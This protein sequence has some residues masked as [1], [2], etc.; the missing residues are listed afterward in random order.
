MEQT[1]A[2][3]AIQGVM[4]MP[5]YTAS[6]LQRVL[7]QGIRA[8]LPYSDLCDTELAIKQLEAR[9]VIQGAL[10]SDPLLVSNLQSALSQGRDANL[11][12]EELKIVEEILGA[13]ETLANLIA[14]T[15]MR[16]RSEEIKN[17]TAYCMPILRG[18]LMTVGMVLDILSRDKPFE[19]VLVSHHISH[20]ISTLHPCSRDLNAS[21][22]TVLSERLPSLVRRAMLQIMEGSDEMQK[23]VMHGMLVDVFRMWKD[24]FAMRAADASACQWPRL[25]HCLIGLPW[26]GL[27]WQAC[28][29]GPCAHLMQLGTFQTM[30]GAA[31]LVVV[32]PCVVELE[33]TFHMDV[34]IDWNRFIRASPPDMESPSSSLVD[35]LNSLYQAQLN[36]GNA[37]PVMHMEWSSTM[38]STAQ[39]RKIRLEVLLECDLDDCQKLE[40]AWKHSGETDVHHFFGRNLEVSWLSSRDA[41]NSSTGYSV[42]SNGDRFCLQLPAAFIDGFADQYLLP[43][44]LLF[45]FLASFGPI[46]KPVKVHR[47]HDKVCLETLY[48]QCDSAQ[49]AHKELAGRYLRL[50]SRDFNPGEQIAAVECAVDTTCADAPQIAARWHPSPESQGA[51]HESPPLTLMPRL[52]SCPSF[53]VTGADKAKA[54]DDAW[55]HSNESEDDVDAPEG[56]TQ[57]EDD[58]AMLSAD[59]D[60]P[61]GETQRENG[62]AM[63]AVVSHDERSIDDEDKDADEAGDKTLQTMRSMFPQRSCGKKCGITACKKLAPF[64]TEAALI[65]HMHDRH[66]KKYL[67]FLWGPEGVRRDTEPYK[68]TM[69]SI[70][71]MINSRKCN[72]RRCKKHHIE[73]NASKL[74]KHLKDDHFQSKN[75]TWKVSHR[76][77]EW[78]QTHEV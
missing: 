36:P 59:V 55:A 77:V 8:Q 42:G 32:A 21:C 31:S 3:H 61:G 78:M 1:E 25:R 43:G 56:K 68:A 16:I 35:D 15:S 33:V 65:E 41:T 10:S 39:K 20:K 38:D 9:Q 54:E 14:S 47:L 18:R 7:S 74:L 62:D 46:S 44:S 75:L 48:S 22:D 49:A 50:W 11:P 51:H 23:V 69:G 58:E 71:N 70:R 28:P 6:D 66:Y 64:K 52:H 76:A 57:R 27:D 24:Q 60:A 5:A 67:R 72:I 4:A 40:L 13:C 29:H 26:T 2:R 53:A 30:D 19:T 37:C 73:M 63:M 34:Q 45:D 12:M 17:I